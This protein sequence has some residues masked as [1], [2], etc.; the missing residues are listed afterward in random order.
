MNSD[1]HGNL[2]F[3]SQGNVTFRTGQSSE[4]GTVTGVWLDGRLLRLPDS[5][6]LIL[7]SRRNFQA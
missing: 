3:V 5:V 2:E 7:Q 6:G 1:N 4:Q